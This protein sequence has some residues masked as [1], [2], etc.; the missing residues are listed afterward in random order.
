MQILKIGSSEVL[1]FF[2]RGANV[3]L[4]DGK[5][6]ISENLKRM[7]EKP[8]TLKVVG[9]GLV[10]TD[11][12]HFSFNLGPTESDEFHELQ[13]VG[14]NS[15]TNSFTKYD[16]TGISNE[17]RK[18]LKPGEIAEKLLEYAAG[19]EVKLLIG[20]K[21]TY[22]DPT[23]IKI[24]PSGVGVY[25]S[26]FRDIFGSRIIFAGPHSCFTSGN[27]ELNNDVNLAVFKLRSIE[28]DTLNPVM[29][30]PVRIVIDKAENISV[31]PSPVSEQ[32]LRE[33]GGEIQNEKVDEREIEQRIIDHKTT[34]KDWY[35]CGVHS[36]RLPISKIRDTQEEAK[37]RR[38][39]SRWSRNLCWK[40]R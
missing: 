7:S 34:G 18:T 3:N 27:H 10:Q 30:I 32:D 26:P 11:Y 35:Q 22:L 25:K 8:S 9:G 40:K 14:M 20:I 24:L 39:I 2:D 13:C 4:I 23:L 29:E 36:T 16:L 19:T 6:A 1:T 31:Y 15:V 21:N 5:L 33:L 17:Y 12:G 37:G 28:R 38:E